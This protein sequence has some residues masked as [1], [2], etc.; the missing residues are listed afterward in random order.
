MNFHSFIPDKN[1]S[2]AFG[3]QALTVLDCK[4]NRVYTALS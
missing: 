4:E 3:R 2:A 1:K